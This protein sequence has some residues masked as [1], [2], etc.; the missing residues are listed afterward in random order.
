M[1][2]SV[3]FSVLQMPELVAG[4]IKAV[5]ERRTARDLYDLHR[6]SAKHP[7]MFDDA[8]ARA[9]AIRAISTADPFPLVF[10]P[11]VSLDGLR[12]LPSESAEILYAMLAADDRPDFEQM[13]SGVS[14]WLA[15]LGMLSDREKEYFRLLDEESVYQPDL[16][17]EQWPDILGR[18]NTDPVMTW[19]VHHLRRRS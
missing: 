3:G 7:A 8:V 11:A 2:D 4:K 16:L 6:L 10:D 15:P 13:V 18:A 17:F 12:D 1:C 14:N 19:K 5:M 9:L